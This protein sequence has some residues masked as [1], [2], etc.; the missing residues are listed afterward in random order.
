M[1]NFKEYEVINTT[2]IVTDTVKHRYNVTITKAEY[3]SCASKNRSDQDDKLFS[4]AKNKIW[5]AIGKNNIYSLVY[6]ADPK[7]Y[8]GDFSEP[9]GRD[10]D[11]RGYIVIGEGGVAVIYYAA[12]TI[13]KVYKSL[14]LDTT[15]KNYKEFAL[16]DSDPPIAT[17]DITEKFLSD[18]L[19]DK[20]MAKFFSEY[21]K[22]K[23]TKNYL[24]EQDKKTRERYCVVKPKNGGTSVDKVVAARAD[25]IESRI[26]DLKYIERFERLKKAIARLYPDLF[27]TDDFKACQ[28]NYAKVTEPTIR[29]YLHE[30]KAEIFLTRLKKD[31]VGE[32]VVETGN[33][34]SGVTFTQPAEADAAAALPNLGVVPVPPPDKPATNKKYEV[35]GKFN[36]KDYKVADPT[37]DPTVLVHKTTGLKIKYEKQTDSYRPI[38]VQNSEVVK[39]QTETKQQPAAAAPSV[40]SAGAYTIINESSTTTPIIT[41]PKNKSSAP[42]LI[43][44]GGSHPPFAQT[45]DRASPNDDYFARNDRMF[46]KAPEEIKKNAIV[47]FAN[48]YTDDDLIEQGKTLAAKNN[49]SITDVKVF[50]FSK[51]GEKILPKIKNGSYAGKVDYLGLMDPSIPAA[52]F[53]KQ[54]TDYP[55]PKTTRLLYNSNNWRGGSKFL[56]DRQIVAD[57]VIKRA[58][59]DRT[60]V[61]T[62]AA[63]SLVPGEFYSNYQAEIIGETTQKEQTTGTASAS[64]DALRNVEVAETAAVPPA[65]ATPPPPAQNVEPAAQDIADAENKILTNFT[66]YDQQCVLLRQISQLLDRP[67]RRKEY[68]NFVRVEDATE[69][70]AIYVSNVIN[71]STLFRPFVNI[72]TYIQAALV[73]KIRLFKTYILSDGKTVDLEIPMEEHIGE[74]DILSGQI[75]RS[76]GYGLEGFSWDNTSF[77]EMD[78]NISAT[79]T[80]KF[81]NM[82][83]FAKEREGILTDPNHPAAALL[84]KFKFL[85]LIYQVP[86]KVNPPNQN[87][88]SGASLI[89]PTKGA[90]PALTT[91]QESFNRFKIKVVV[92]WAFDRNVLMNFKDTYDGDITKLIN[93]IEANNLVLYLYNKGHDM[94]F[95][96]YGKTVLTINYQSAQEARMNDANR[97]NILGISASQQEEAIAET[98]KQIEESKKDETTDDTEKAK[99][100][101]AQKKKEDDSN[102]KIYQAFLDSFFKANIIKVARMNIKQLARLK[103]ASVPS[104]S[105][106]TFVQITFDKDMEGL[107]NKTSSETSEQLKNMQQS[108]NSSTEAM[109][110]SI[111]TL[112][113]SFILKD[114]KES[115]IIPYFHLGDL[116]D[117]ILSNINNPENDKGSDVLRI[118]TGPFVYRRLENT[119]IKQLQQMNSLPSGKQ[120]VDI[121]ANIADIPIS[122][123]LFM[124]WFQSE[125][126]AQKRRVYT[127]KEFFSLLL[128]KFIMTALSPNCFGKN[129]VSGNPKVETTLLNL[130]AVN[131]NE[132]ITGRPVTDD[133]F[134]GILAVSRIKDMFDQ[135]ANYANLSRVDV[136]PY[137]YL[138]MLYSD[139][140]YRFEINEAKN[141]LQNIYHL[142]LGVDRGLVKNI[143]F[144]KDDNQHI[145]V[146][147][148][149]Q[150]GTVNPR[151][152]RTPYN[153]Q[154]E[155]YGNNIFKPGNLVYIDPTY[156]LSIPEHKIDGGSVIEEIGLGGFYIVTKTSN[157]IGTQGFTTSLSCKFTNYGLRK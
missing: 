96:Q 21:A 30:K 105:D 70:Q 113:K 119:S 44:Y 104:A 19:A 149:T 54:L 127:M 152:L 81:S 86:S 34:S 103:A 95:D 57:R 90:T 3:D 1:A 136:V 9:I 126:V 49:I 116:L 112:R 118:I 18:Y 101:E 137:V 55:W 60:S 91:F 131:G 123:E 7:D 82:D 142:K 122:F 121:Q 35:K 88:G 10:I 102:F 40:N 64:N 147:T 8:G 46:K 132:Q 24:S 17:D 155:M 94:Q 27:P 43:I 138:Q 48:Y 133:K 87:D 153:A 61:F 72:P 75:A 135:Y 6:T 59:G 20:A 14:L 144:S 124:T 5:N 33:I 29:A 115:I 154:V 39:K 41:I 62:S 98:A 66:K 92:G 130:K 89:D 129:F 16:K 146:Y 99:A 156:M 13:Q 58:G 69:E 76:F 67:E 120:T 22:D 15:N 65:V 32:E 106:S 114:D 134:G 77:N 74:K 150:Q 83:A 93:A 128:N 107:A 56:G 111:E 78:R 50:G 42:L 108:G 148:Y 151:M 145:P 157:K 73:P 63:H 139:V 36:L 68:E 4:L 143:N 84:K 80:L 25:I 47:F 97:S 11:G 31:L 52:V 117:L 79:L 85:E 28:E 100:E 2:E 125:V 141:E 71:G 110:N 26:A 37:G 38:G 53:G 51:G 140:N 12:R 45:K 23:T 109:N